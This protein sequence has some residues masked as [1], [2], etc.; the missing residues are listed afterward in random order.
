MLFFSLLST[1]EQVEYI[2]GRIFFCKFTL[3]YPR[4]KKKKCKILGL[5]FAILNK[6]YFSNALKWEPQYD[7]MK[8]KSVANC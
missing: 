7:L 3:N 5:S 2:N 6:T 4:R 1:K 8:K